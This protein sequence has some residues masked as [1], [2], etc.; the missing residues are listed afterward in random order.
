MRCTAQSKAVAI[1]IHKMAMK[2]FVVYGREKRLMKGW[3]RMDKKILN[4][5]Q[6]KVLRGLY[7]PV[8]EQGIWVIRNNQKLS[9][10]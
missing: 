3:I 10:P 4:T 9:R 6:R 8:V 2:S 1:K 7:G 5:W